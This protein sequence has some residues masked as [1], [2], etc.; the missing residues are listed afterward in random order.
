MWSTCSIET[1]H[2][3]QAPQVTQSQTTSSVTAPDERVGF[4]ACRRTVLLE[5]AVAKAHDEEPATAP[6]R[7]PA[8]QAS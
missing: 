7:S 5:E 2:R 3:T 1:G 4:A 8:G 6:R